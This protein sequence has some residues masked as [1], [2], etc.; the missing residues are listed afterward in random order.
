MSR[1]GGLLTKE[2][3]EVE[4]LWLVTAKLVMK[5]EGEGRADD[6]SISDVLTT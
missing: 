4:G 6:R 5:C 1:E 3:D 2:T